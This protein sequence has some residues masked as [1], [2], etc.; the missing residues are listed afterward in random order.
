V[1]VAAWRA[2]AILRQRTSWDG[3]DTDRGRIN[4]R[5]EQW[6]CFEVPGTDDD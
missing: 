4:E 1:V 6:L 5:H 2:R 3:L